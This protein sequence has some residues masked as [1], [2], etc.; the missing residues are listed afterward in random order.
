M[1]FILYSKIIFGFDLVIKRIWCALF[2]RE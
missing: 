2:V 1:F